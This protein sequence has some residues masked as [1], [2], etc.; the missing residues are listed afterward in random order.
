VYLLELFGGKLSLSDILETE[1][2]LL[3]QIHDAKLRFLENIQKN[4][5]TK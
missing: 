2:P 4:K 5:K 3:T 1:I